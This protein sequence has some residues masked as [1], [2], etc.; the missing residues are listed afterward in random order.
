VSTKE[1]AEQAAQAARFPLSGIRGADPTVRSAKYMCG[2]FDWD[3]FI[4]KSNDE[5]MVIPLLEN[6][7]FVPNIEE[8]L[9]VEGIDA[10]SFGPTDF[11][12]S[13]GLN[14]L[15]DFDHPKIVEAFDAVVDCANRKNKPVL[16]AVN[17]PTVE[18]SNALKDKSVRFL[19][20]GSDIGI[21]AGAFNRLVTEVVSKIK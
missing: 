3:A 1:D 11:A 5:I 4:K 15:Y 14:L 7:A 2:D 6:K 12:L 13:L 10:V 21:I 18:Q 9:S 8:I 16:A 17:P 20:Y 19:L